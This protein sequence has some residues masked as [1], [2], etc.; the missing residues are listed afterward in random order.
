MTI[1]VVQY[2][3]KGVPDTVPSLRQLGVVIRHLTPK[4]NPDENPLV[5]YERDSSLVI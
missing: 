1:E 4:V 3:S 2:L 5:A